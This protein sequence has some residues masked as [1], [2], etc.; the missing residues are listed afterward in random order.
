MSATTILMGSMRQLPPG[1]SS[2]GGVLRVPGWPLIITAL[3]IG[4]GFFVAEHDL[5]VSRAISYTQDEEQMEVTAAG[6]NALRRAAFFGIATWGTGLLFSAHGRL[7]P[8]PLLAGGLAVL[9]GLAAISFLWSEDRGM[10]LRRLSSLACCVVGAAGIARALTLREIAWLAIFVFG[11]LAIVGI[12]AE[13]RLGTFRP[14]T[15]DYR[16]AGTVH[17]NTQAAGLATVCIAAFCLARG[18]TGRNA[19]TWIAFALGL[20]L[21]VLTKSR[22]T[23]AGIFLAIAVGPLLETRVRTKIGGALAA[24][25]LVC[26]AVWLLWICGFDLPGDFRDALLLGRAEESDTLSGRA[27]IWPEVLYFAQQRLLFGYGYESFW[28]PAHIETISSNLGWGLREAHNAYLEAL[29]SLG[30]VGLTTLLFVAVVAIALSIRGY[31][32]MRDPM[33]FFPLGLT[34]FAMINAGCESGMVVVNL[35]SFVLGCCLFR[36]ALFE[37]QDGEIQRKREREEKQINA[38]APSSRLSVSPS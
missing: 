35:V 29:L 13:M 38:L 24:L 8:E 15:A 4:I 9:L 32:T 20:L 28:T 36:L 22:T 34:V 26:A 30:V 23:T 12:L 25:W 33:Y 11:G 2:R 21:L 3:V 10:C 6:G 31:R 14:W 37:R 5:N 17:P 7:K 18:R 16:F 27:F 1:E 19:C